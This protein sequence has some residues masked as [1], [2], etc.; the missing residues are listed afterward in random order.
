MTDP[1]LPD[2][3]IAAAATCLMELLPAL[4]L[5]SP[6]ERDGDV[7]AAARAVVAAALEGVVI[8][9]PPSRPLLRKDLRDV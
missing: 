6:D 2:S 5:S 3:A 7:H 9:V 8:V 1:R 4:I